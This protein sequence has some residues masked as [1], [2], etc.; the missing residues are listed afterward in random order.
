MNKITRRTA[1]YGIAASASL[2][3]AREKATAVALIGDDLGVSIDFCDKVKALDA[4]TLRGY[5]HLIMLRD[6]LWPDRYTAPNSGPG[7]I[8]T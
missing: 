4:D 2:V 8:T 7:A 6:V 3:C 1:I 5:R